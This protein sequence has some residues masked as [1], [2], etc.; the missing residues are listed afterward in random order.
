MRQCQ[1]TKPLMLVH[2][3]R[4]TSHQDWPVCRG[5]TIHVIWIPSSNACRISSKCE[6]ASSH[7]TIQFQRSISHFQ[8]LE[9][10]H[11]SKK[12]MGGEISKRL[13]EVF[14]QLWKGKY[15]SIAKNLFSDAFRERCEPFRGDRQQDA[16]EFF[17]LLIHNLAK[18]LGSP[19]SDVCSTSTSFAVN[20]SI[21]LYY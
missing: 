10:G 2:S 4:S 21:F 20:K 15:K 16:H 9:F 1:W 11:F 12:Q 14:G 8:P 18:E 7:G 19:I 6:H 13:A 3:I 17:T 5:L